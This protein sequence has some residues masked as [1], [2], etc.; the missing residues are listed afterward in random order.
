MMRGNLRNSRN[1]EVL[2]HI[3]DVVGEDSFR[4][5][6]VPGADWHR[7]AGM[8]R[9]GMLDR[10]QYSKRKKENGV[11]YGG[12]QA[13]WRIHAEWVSILRGEKMRRK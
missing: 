10:V 4:A 1:G 8:R 7:F 9:M 11:E 5:S 12:S 6:D 13:I 2:Q 3:Y